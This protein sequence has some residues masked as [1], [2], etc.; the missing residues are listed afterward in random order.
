MPE[1]AKIT[2]KKTLPKRN[3]ISDVFRILPR[4]FASDLC[5]FIIFSAFRFPPDIYENSMRKKNGFY[6]ARAVRNAI[7]KAA[8]QGSAEKRKKR[9]V[10][11]KVLF[12]D[13]S[14]VD[15]NLVRLFSVKGAFG[16]RA[17]DDRLQTV[18]SAYEFFAPQRIQF[19]HHVV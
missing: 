2:D 9:R 18:D 11:K 14:A 10:T 17:G 13:L 8:R 1:K 15:T 16:V 4:F 6:S 12:H 5:I 3:V 19:A 7:N